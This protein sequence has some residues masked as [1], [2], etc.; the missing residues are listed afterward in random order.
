MMMSILNTI[1]RTFGA[2]AEPPPE[3]PPPEELG[4]FSIGFDGGFA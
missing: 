1:M 2:I 3:E 4:A